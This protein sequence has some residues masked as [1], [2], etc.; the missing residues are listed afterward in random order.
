M[1]HGIRNVRVWRR[2]VDLQQFNPVHRTQAM[3][4][5][6]T[7]GHPDR[8]IAVYVGRI[9]L[10]KGLHRLRGMFADNPHLHLALVG[11]GPAR[12]ELEAYFAGTPTTFLGTLHGRDLAAAYASGDVF[13]FPSTTETL[14]L[15]I[16]EAMASGMP[17]VAAGTAPTHELI[18]GSGAGALFAA[19]HP[20]QIGPLVRQLLD[21]MNGSGLVSQRARREAEKWGWR[22]PTEELEV[23]YQ[24]VRQEYQARS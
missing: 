24:E 18:D 8:E 13:V 17:V 5:R 16:L 1:S 19:E 20:E 2:G 15:V 7:D 21:T 3:R 23:L 12:E 11:D 9:A 4:E 6:M 22:I 14:G 10:E